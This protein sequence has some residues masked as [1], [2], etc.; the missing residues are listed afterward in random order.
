MKKAPKGSGPMVEK[1]R[2][3]SNFIWSR[4]NGVVVGRGKYAQCAEDA[5]RNLEKQKKRLCGSSTFQAFGLNK[6]MFVSIGSC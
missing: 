6:G 2:A 5:A 4:D 1:S 3:R